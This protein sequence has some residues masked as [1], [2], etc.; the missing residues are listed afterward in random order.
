MSVEEL[1]EIS[2]RMDLTET[3]SAECLGA[4]LCLKGIADLSRLPKGTLLKFPSGVE[5]S[6]EQYNSPRHEMGK[7]IAATYAT[8]SGKEI[9]STAFSRAAKLSRGLIGVVEAAGTI[10]AGD[11]VSVV[12]Y[13]H[14]S[15]LSGR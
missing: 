7:K 2:K 8:N 11:E 4:N 12:I 10:N 6:V 5:L 15:W 14:P 3:L 9:P 13:E 1:D